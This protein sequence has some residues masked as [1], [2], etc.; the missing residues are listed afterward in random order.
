MYISQTC[1]SMV[2]LISF[3]FRLRGKII[4]WLSYGIT[5]QKT[6]QLY[7]IQTVNNYQ[8]R[9]Y[10]SLML[11]HLIKLVGSKTTI[12]AKIMGGRENQECIR[13]LSKYNFKI[14]DKDGEIYMIKH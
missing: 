9:G 14:I 12:I 7:T 2:Y 1:Q 11:D 5:P 8:H 3:R 10:G 6:V 13:L 4:C